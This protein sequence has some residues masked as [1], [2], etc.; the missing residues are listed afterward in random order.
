MS[1][2]T[3]TPGSLQGT[4]RA[5]PSK[6]AAHRL[7]ICAAL[8]DKPTWVYCDGTSK[9]IE[10]T[11]RCLNALGADIERVQDRCYVTPVDRWYRKDK[12]AVLPCGESGSTLRFLLPVAAVLGVNAIFTMEG[13][14][15]KRPIFP[16]SREL[17][18]HGCRLEYLPELE[19]WHLSGRLRGGAFSLPGDVSSQFLTGLLLALPLGGRDSTLTITGPMESAGYVDMTL[20]A[21]GAFQT[22]PGKTENGWKI[23]AL[24]YLSPGAVQVEGDWSNAAPWLCAGAVAGSGVTV[25]GLAMDSSQGD[26]AVCDI[27]ERMG[28]EVTKTADSVTVRPGTLHGIEVDGRNVP[29]LIPVLAATAAQAEG[30]TRFLQVGRLRLKESDRLTATVNL[31]NALGGKAEEEGDTLIVHGTGRLSGG[32]V[33]TVND[34]RMVMAAA[35]AS[36]GCDSPVT[37]NYPEAVNKSYPGFFD[38]LD[39]L[40]GEGKM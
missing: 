2:K 26:R 12:Q 24:G 22:K 30:T 37:V 8:A 31:L 39:A 19:A 18:A 33:D 11:V 20:R 9:D 25:T 34:H 15:S 16:L 32:T 28:A 5:I 27:L 4:V 13:R 7:L 21:M 38:T 1:N 3:I 23:P 35:V 10:A 17:T 6:S 29:D 40:R 36:I 14:L